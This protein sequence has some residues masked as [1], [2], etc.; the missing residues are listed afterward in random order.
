[1]SKGTVGTGWSLVWRHKKILIWVFVVNLV[2]GVMAAN[3]PRVEFSSVLDQSVQSARLVNG[4]DVGT[5][6]ELLNRQVCTPL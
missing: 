2:L 4:F 5:F 3:A 6:V 1:M